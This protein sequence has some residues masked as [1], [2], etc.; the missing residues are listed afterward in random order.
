MRWRYELV[1]SGAACDARSTDVKSSHHPSNL[2]LDGKIRTLIENDD[3]D[4]FDDLN[5]ILQINLSISM[6]QNIPTK[7]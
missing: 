5:T 6:K 2:I 1:G 7:Y 3:D 4:D